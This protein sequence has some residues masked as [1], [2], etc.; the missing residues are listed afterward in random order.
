[1]SPEFLRDTLRI[2]LDDL[3]A[4]LRAADGA[5]TP[6]ERR[7]L[8][9]AGTLAARLRIRLDE[10]DLPRIASEPFARA[11]HKRLQATGALDILAE[12]GCALDALEA[13]L[14]EA[15]AAGAAA[16]PTPQ[17][18]GAG[19]VPL[20]DASAFSWYGSWLLRDED[21]PLLGTDDFKEEGAEGLLL[22]IRE[23]A[24]DLH[25]Y[26]REK[27][28]DAQRAEVDAASD[29]E[30]PLD[31]VRTVLAEINMVMQREPILDRGITGGIDALR[32][33]LLTD[34]IEELRGTYREAM[35][36]LL[37][38]RRVLE[39]AFPNWIEEFGGKAGN[40]FERFMLGA[41]GYPRNQVF[42]TADRRFVMV[43][44]KPILLGED[45]EWHEAPLFSE[46]NTGQMWFSFE[47]I[48]AEKF[49]ITVQV[50]SILG[51][52][53]KAIWHNVQAATQIPGHAAG[54]AT[55][56]AI[57]YADVLQQFLFGKP[58][59]AYTLDTGGRHLRRFGKTW[60][61]ALGLRTLMTLILSFQGRH[62]EAPGGNQ[63][64]FW[65][66]VILGD[67]IRTATP[68]LFI[69]TLRDFVF[70]FL[71]LLNSKTSGTGAIP[72]NPARNRLKQEP[73]AALSD[74]LWTMLHQNLYNADDYS[75]FIWDPDEGTGEQKLRAYLGFWV[76]GSA[77]NG[78]VS[79]V[80]TS[81]ASQFTSRTVDFG[82]FGETVGF[83]MLRTF[84]G[85]WFQNYLLKEGDTDGG[86]YNPLRTAAGTPLAT[87]FTGYPAKATSPY[88][89]PL[90]NDETNYVGQGNLALFS[91]NLI[92][93]TTT[94]Q[95]YAYDFAHDLQ[96]P[97]RA[98]RDGTIVEITEGFEDSN[99]EDPNRLVIR[100]DTIV[101]DHD[102]FLGPN[103]RTYAI[104]LH[105]AQNGITNAFTN[106]G[107]PAPSV[108][109]TVNQ[110][111]IVALAGDT[112]L[113]FHNH[114]HMHV[115]VE[116]G[117]GTDTRGNLPIPWVFSD[118]PGDGVLKA[119]TWYR[120]DRG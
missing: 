60:D 67:A 34:D 40:W 33:E 80:T 87:S 54:L 99:T 92:L 112:G 36:L 3:I 35:S 116:A 83:S 120:P 49:E 15:Q 62:S 63:F 7:R 82:L 65:V 64:A 104:Y 90:A 48:P 101:P 9:L 118:A 109:D 56:T 12:A 4:R 24:N 29:N 78:L 93:N 96:G 100:H 37:Y 32:P 14:A 59:S 88:R 84:L 52:L 46:S 53:G 76:L 10:V 8:R 19:V 25:R 39:R 111:D 41:I 47:L 42:V 51:D 44:D 79:G 6:D 23:P 27:L 72:S 115:V 50:I 58:L 55:V 66:T 26:I 5:G 22:N 98:V 45:V 86:T 57:D 28:T 108:G 119:T 21:L 77:V 71:T 70:S 69:N 75:I 95:V 91:H 18:V 102:G 113:S 73:I 110:G 97:I 13:S 85:F 114:L 106:R 89:L 94:P 16:R 107:A 20:D 105:L 117:V 81:L 1:M 68:I 11:I 74:Q 61:S 2:L 30:P 103:L 17:P 31:V 38:N 43:D